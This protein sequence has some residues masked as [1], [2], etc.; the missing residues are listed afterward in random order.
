MKK[1]VLLVAVLV[2][3]LCQAKDVTVGSVDEVKK[4][5]KYSEP[6]DNVI[7]KDGK[8]TD[9]DIAFV[10]QGEK[11]KPITIAPETPGG[12]TFSGKSRLRIGGQH[13]VISGFRF[14]NIRKVSDSLQLRRDSRQPAF[15]CRVTDCV[16]D[17]DED[18]V[19]GDSES[20]WI[21]I[22]GKRNEI[23]HCCF[24]GKKSRG[25]TF[26]VWLTKA[27]SGGHKIHH[28][29]F[30]QRSKLGKNGGE[31][32]RIGD[33]ETSLREAKCL[34][35]HNVFQRCNG[36]LECVSN[37]SCENIYR[38]NLFHKVEGTLSLRHGNRCTIEGNQFFGDDLK[39]TGG[40]RIIGEDH[41]IKDNYLANLGGIT[42]RGA[43]VLQ[44]GIADSPL[45]GYGPVRRAQVLNNIVVDCRE[46]L[47]MGY[48][49]KDAK[50]AKVVPADCVFR[51]NQFYAP[52]DRVVVLEHHAARDTQWKSNF[53]LGK[54]LGMDE[55]DGIRFMAR[56][57]FLE[58][59]PTRPKFDF[60]KEC[61]ASWDSRRFEP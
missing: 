16:F 27:D 57:D 17:T 43:I 41:L 12:V 60:A 44:N 4:A 45:N 23:D 11:G 46:S 1:L 33:S 5:I 7:L 21:G 35:E 13:L 36:E 32:L 49:D 22:Y 26:V 3:Q 50:K 55:T 29:L 31:T 8:W 47:V 19:A 59:T 61:G 51:G 56:K 30:G 10:A 38:E 14:H 58:V 52:D 42:G 24:E 25:T 28:N 34:V 39:H 54:S 18:F 6:G 48:A 2:P 9:V 53:A 15:D 40:I 37:K 20:R